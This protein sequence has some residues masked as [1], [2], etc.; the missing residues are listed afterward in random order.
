MEKADRVFRRVF[1]RDEARKG[2]A[3]EGEAREGE[4]PAEPK[5]NLTKHGDDPNGSTT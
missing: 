1:R 2:E 5:T 4:A 3:R